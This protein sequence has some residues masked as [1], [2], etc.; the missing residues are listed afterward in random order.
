MSYSM[1]E[2][3]ETWIKGTKRKIRKKT[4]VK[5]KYLTKWW[6]FY[7]NMQ[8]RRK[9]EKNDQKPEEMGGLNNCLICST[10]FVWKVIF[11]GL[12]LQASYVPE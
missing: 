2:V 5:E 8:G 6:L 3:V 11:Q 4:V 1:F 7:C 9:S 12:I 10:C